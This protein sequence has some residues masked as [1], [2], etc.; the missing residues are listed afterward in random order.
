MGRY[1]VS[2]SPARSVVMGVEGV[3]VERK[4]IRAH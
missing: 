1:Y 4:V 2:H 3:G